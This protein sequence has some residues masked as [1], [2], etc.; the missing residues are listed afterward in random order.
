MRILQGCTGADFAECVLTHL[1]HMGTETSKLA[2]I[3]R[4][5]EQSKHLETATMKI[6]G[7]SIDFVNLRT[8]EYASG[9]RI[10][11]IRLGTAEEDALRRDLTI[12]ALF[13]RVEGGEIEDLCGEGL[14]DLEAGIARTPLEPVQT[15]K[16]DPLR[17]LRAV[18]FACRFDLSVHRGLAVAAASAEVTTALGSKVSRERLGVEVQKMLTGP[19]PIRALYLLYSMGLWDVV[20]R[21]PSRAEDEDE[22]QVH[23]VSL[24]SANGLAI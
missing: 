13:Y 17:V 7:V 22:D 19:Q 10:P 5:P 20:F 2:I 21:M 18:R 6:H 1:K 11:E 12:N 3:E 14:A 24:G 23:R 9:S 15:F 8:E 16:D 4:N